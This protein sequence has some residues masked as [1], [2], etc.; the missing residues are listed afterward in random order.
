M[1]NSLGMRKLGI[2]N[3]VLKG[4]K[5]GEGDEEKVGLKGEPRGRERRG[6]FESLQKVGPFTSSQ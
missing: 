1:C 3:S 4:K 6:F 2:S 5:E